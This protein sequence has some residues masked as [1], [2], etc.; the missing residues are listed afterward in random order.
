M[1]NQLYVDMDGVLCDFLGG[2]SKILGYELKTHAEWAAQRNV[3]WSLVKDKGVD[4]WANLEWM[5]GGREL[6]EAV[7]EHNPII[8]SAFP[9]MEKLR[10]TAMMGKSQWLSKNI[11][12]SVASSAIYCRVDQKQDLAPIGNCLIDD[13][14]RTIMQ[15]DTRGGIGI[16]HISTENTIKELK[17]HANLYL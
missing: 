12:K 13:N 16:L 10:A 9:M 2:V 1:I 4:F 6:W 11:N 14:K 7:K 17:K 8:L 5:P 3:Y 15:W